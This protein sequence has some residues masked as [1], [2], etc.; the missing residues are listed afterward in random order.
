[1]FTIKVGTNLGEMIEEMNVA[2]RAW[3]LRA[4]RGECGWI[5]G[6]CCSSFPEGM[7]EACPHEDKR[8][9]EILQRNKASALLVQPQKDAK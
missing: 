7:P 2:T 3:E 8:C 1:M 6:D 5:C 9:T 4:A